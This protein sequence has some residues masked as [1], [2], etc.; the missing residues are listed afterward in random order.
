MKRPADV[1]KDEWLR[2]CIQTADSLE[3]P[4]KPAYLGGMAMLGNLDY[5]TEQILEMI[6]RH[7]MH[8]SDLYQYMSANGIRE[9]RREDILQALE[10]RLQPEEAQQF[11]PSLERIED[12]QQLSKL[13]RAAVLADSPEDFQ[14]VL[15]EHSN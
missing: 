1:D 15:D 2:R 9:G 13:H 6:R 8:E 5:E 10:I 14:E 7:T 3:V 12:L 11:K 4:D